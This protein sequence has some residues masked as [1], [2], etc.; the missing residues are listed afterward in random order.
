MARIITAYLLG[1]KEQGK[2]VILSI[3]IKS[4]EKLGI[5]IGEKA[6]KRRCEKLNIKT[7]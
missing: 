4:L 5:R 7:I 3:A 6:L 2:P 1:L